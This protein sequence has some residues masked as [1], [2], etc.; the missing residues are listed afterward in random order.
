MSLRLKSLELC[1]LEH[2]SNGRTCGV[3]TICGSVVIVSMLL[4]STRQIL[5]EKEVERPIVVESN[6]S[7]T[8]K[9]GRPKKVI[10]RTV[11]DIQTRFEKGY[12]VETNNKCTN[13][14]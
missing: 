7:P 14:I 3:H 5:E 12:A 6:G 10:T 11:K 2:G 9:R 1:G 13:L 4:K 8:Q